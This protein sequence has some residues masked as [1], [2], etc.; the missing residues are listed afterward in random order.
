MTITILAVVFLLIILTVA[1][2]GFKAVIRQGRSPDDINREKCSLC[3]LTFNKAQL[4]ERQVGDQR[5]FHFCHACVSSLY[6]ELVS[7]N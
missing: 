7:K 1:V 5:L 4:I 6:T 2:L 3:R